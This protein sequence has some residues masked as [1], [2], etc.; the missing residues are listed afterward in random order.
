MS[1]LTYKQLLDLVSEGVIEGVPL[2]HINAAS[3][4]LTLGPV[5]HVEKRELS[6]RSV[7]L[8]KKEVPE[9]TEISLLNG[10]YDLMPGEFVLAQTQE[11]F[12]LPAGA[13]PRIASGLR[14][15]NHLESVPAIAAEFKLKSSLARA[16]L[17]H[18]L[19]GW[20]D[21]GWNGSVLTL[22]LHNCNRY[23]ML[24]LTAGMKIGQIVLWA[25]QPVPTEA[26]YATRGQYNGDLT[27]TPSKGI[28]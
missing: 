22:E 10:P 19:A 28:R 5:L 12:N 21:P 18:L 6:Y 27:A 25:G 13:V 20:C 17:N 11:V 4:D 7:D 24:R 23:N 14:Q 8:V 9:T 16:G 1:L 2:D 3:I 26:S 15:Q